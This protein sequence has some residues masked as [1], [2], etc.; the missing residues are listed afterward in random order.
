ME[1]IT[2]GKD[3]PLIGCIQFGLIIRD[4]NWVQIRATTVC[5]MKCTFCSTSANDFSLHP[6]NFVVELDHLVHWA[7]QIL[8]TISEELE[9]HID[10][11]GEPTAYPHLVELIKQLKKIKQVHKISMQTNG[12]FLTKQLI[13]DLA[14]AG[15]HRINLSLHSLNTTQ[16]KELFDKTSYNLT[17]V[18]E[19]IQYITQN[20]SIELL[21]APVYL[22]GVTDEEIEKIIS[23]AIQNNCLIGIQ[24]YEVYRYS[25]KH[26]KAKLINWFKFNKQLKLWEKK[27]PIKLMYKEIPKHAQKRVPKFPLTF[28]IGQK[29]S[30]Q[31]VAPGWHKNQMLAKAK[32]R[33]I[34]INK[35]N[36]KVG[37]LVNIKIIENSKNIYLAELI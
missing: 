6:Y 32:D 3:I 28:K 11:V 5:N 22:P 17:T 31:I 29:I 14:H 18:V 1:L 24:K 7:K 15:L 27:Y 13:D 30:A 20:T 12:T 23:F 34:T 9:V 26:K 36:K 35:C 21:L 16:A 19:M 37:D 33:V 2:I 25:R 10:S 4:T 8:P